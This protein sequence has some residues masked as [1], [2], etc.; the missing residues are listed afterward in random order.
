VD[1]VLLANHCRF[2]LGN[3]E[4]NPECH[5]DYNGNDQVRFE[6]FHFGGGSLA[7]L[8]ARCFRWLLLFVAFS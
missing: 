2:E 8:A 3:A 1:L 4:N 6:F 5:K 7:G